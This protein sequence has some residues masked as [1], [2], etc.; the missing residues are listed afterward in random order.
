LLG[1]RILLIEDSDDIR[2]FVTTV[3]RM[4]GGETVA[5][6][7][8]EEG[9]ERL[10]DSGPFDLILLDIN[11]PGMSGWDLL[12]KLRAEPALAGPAPILIFTAAAD[13]ATLEKARSYSARDVIVKPIAARELVERLNAALT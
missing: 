10:D 9:L 8:G 5:A 3:V 6:G 4:E 2:I 7:S 12:E 13:T 11:L 1:K